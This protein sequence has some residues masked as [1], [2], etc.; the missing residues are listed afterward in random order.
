[1]D[2]DQGFSNSRFDYPC[3]VVV[4]RGLVPKGVPTCR[5]GPDSG[6]AGLEFGWDGL[7]RTP[8]GLELGPATS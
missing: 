2:F 4:V 5:G 7:I 3:L 8:W 6:G 1:M